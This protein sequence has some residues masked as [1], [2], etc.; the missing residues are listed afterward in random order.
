M[1]QTTS[2]TIQADIDHTGGVEQRWVVSISNHTWVGD[3]RHVA[4]IYDYTWDGDRRRVTRIYGDELRRW[5]DAE[6][7][8]FVTWRQVAR[9]CLQ[10]Y[11]L[12]RGSHQALQRRIAAALRGLGWTP[13]V[14][15][16]KRGWVRLV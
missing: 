7:Y 9:D 2:H 5:L 11:G 13:Q 6:A 15:R 16:K 8:A 1:F 10:I 3:R 12:E 4:R 14:R